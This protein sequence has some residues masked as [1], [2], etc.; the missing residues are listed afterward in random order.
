M[1]AENSAFIEDLNIFRGLARGMEM[2]EIDNYPDII[3]PH[4]PEDFFG[5]RK[6]AKLREGGQFDH[7]ANTMILPDRGN[8][9]N[10]AR[11]DFHD[12]LLRQMVNAIARK[13]HDSFG[14]QSLSLFG[15]LAR[16]TQKLGEWFGFV[17]LDMVERAD[18]TDTQ[19]SSSIVRPS[20]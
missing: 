4:S 6:A 5:L 15:N 7:V 13:D 18:I 1:Y 19:T 20:V 17:T 8:R 11:H 2:P 9:R 14:T 12:L 10:I 3:G 16:L